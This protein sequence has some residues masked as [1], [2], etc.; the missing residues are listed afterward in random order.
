MII[1]KG[2]QIIHIV[3]VHYLL[4]NARCPS[5]NSDQPLHQVTAPQFTGRM[6]YGVEYRFGQ[7]GSPVPSLFPLSFF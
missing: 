6:F 7:L 1:K 4:P 5:P 3:I 2:K